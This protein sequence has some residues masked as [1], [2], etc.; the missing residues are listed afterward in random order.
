MADATERAPA[1]GGAVT[2]DKPDTASAPRWDPAPGTASGMVA[3]PGHVI[4]VQGVPRYHKSGCIL[5]RFLGQSDLE[6]LTRE[7]A[8]AAGC[9][10]CRA[11]QPDKSELSGPAQPER[12]A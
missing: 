10:P 3:K 9:V 6:Q 4:V 7:A 8:E 5:I 12:Q 1:F 11:C 2:P